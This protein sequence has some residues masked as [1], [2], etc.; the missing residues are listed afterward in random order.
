VCFVGE[1]DSVTLDVS[2]D[3]LRRQ[4][5]LV[6]S[7]TFST[8]GQ[9]ECAQFVADR[10]IPVDLLFSHHFTLPQANEAYTLFDTQS[11]GKGVFVI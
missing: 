4:I 8:L 9:A 7:W 11:T 2:Q 10:K 1:G 5:T 6:G 3:L